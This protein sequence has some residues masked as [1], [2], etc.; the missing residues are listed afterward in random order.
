MTPITVVNAATALERSDG[1]LQNA[2]VEI[3]DSLQ[4]ESDRDV[5]RR[6]RIWARIAAAV[7][8]QE[9]TTLPAAL[10]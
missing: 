4:E 2:L 3:R 1:W 6:Q 9:T 8:E 5:N 10:R 7:E